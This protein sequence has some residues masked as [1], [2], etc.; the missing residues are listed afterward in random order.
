MTE[1]EWDKIIPKK[2][3]FKELNKVIKDNDVIAPMS[4]GMFTAQLMTNNKKY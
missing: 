4:V 3:M 1:N 2:P